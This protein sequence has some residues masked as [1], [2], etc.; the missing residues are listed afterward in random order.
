MPANLPLLKTV[1]QKVPSEPLRNALSA[2]VN[3][4]GFEGVLTKQE[5]TQLAAKG[6]IS[7]NQLLLTL[8]EVA[9]VYAVP[10]ISNFYVGAIAQGASTESFYMGANMEF[11][12][13]ALSFTLHAEQAATANAWNNEEEGLKLI[14][15]NAA[16]CGYC[17]QFLYEITTA[18]KLQIL[19]AGS[20]PEPLT[21]LLPQAFGPKDLGVEEAEAL[22]SSQFHDLR[23]EEE[24]E[25]NAVLMALVA[26]NQSYA[27]APYTEPPHPCYAGVAIE[28]SA[29]IFSGRLADN[30]AYNPSLSPLEAAMAMW[31]FG[32]APNEPV[33]RVVLVQSKG[34]V[35]DQAKATEA[36]VETLPGQPAFEQYWA[37]PAA[38]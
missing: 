16:P 29:Q 30:A 4:T 6:G 36:V 8:A 22:M 25:D 11:A 32:A 23:L 27:P 10:S 12:G 35:A 17:R 1:L 31:T 5:A 34:T 2:M 38:G 14:A 18:K 21:T 3:E 33:T 19:L 20:N 28:T 26:A 13:E 9:K 7:L 15:V 37:V 24:T